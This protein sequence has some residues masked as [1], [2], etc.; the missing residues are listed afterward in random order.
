MITEPEELKGWKT[1][2]GQI[3]PLKSEAR[4]HQA[5]LELR[6]WLHSGEP[7]MGSASMTLLEWL[8]DNWERLDYLL[9][10]KA[11]GHYYGPEE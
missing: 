1:T 3:H 4:S 10:V 5:D 6:E 7:P 8:E 2:D 11:S 9:S